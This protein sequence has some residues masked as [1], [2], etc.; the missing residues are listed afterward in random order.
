MYPI[1]MTTNFVR[2]GRVLLPLACGSCAVAN[3]P[4]VLNCANSKQTEGLINVC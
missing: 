2:L 4:P 1:A 3:C